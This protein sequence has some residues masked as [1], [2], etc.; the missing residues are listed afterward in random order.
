MN[1]DLGAYDFS[2]GADDKSSSHDR[3]QSGRMA[4][5]QKDLRH[6]REVLPRGLACKLF[7]AKGPTR[8]GEP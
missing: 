7:F 4:C 1:Q 2:Y 3:R 8:I 5:S 6:S